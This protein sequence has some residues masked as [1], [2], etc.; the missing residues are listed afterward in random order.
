[1]VV[2]VGFFDGVHIG[3]RRVI[4]TLLDRG[5]DAVAVTFW[6]HPRVVLQQEAAGF[7]LLDTPQ[8]KLEKLNRAGITDVR[9]L[10]F[11]KAF[12]GKTAEQFIKE[13]LKDSL[14]CNCLVMGSDNSLG[15]DAVGPDKLAALCDRY[16]IETVVVPPCMVDG[17]KVSSSR[18]RECIGKGEIEEAN[19]MLG[20][21]YRI[22][23]VVVSGNR[24]GRTIGF[25]TINLQLSFPLKA[26]P[27]NGV[28]A[29]RTFIDGKQYQSMT[30][31]GVRPTVTAGMERVIETNIFDFNDDVY[32]Y[33]ASVEFISGI[34][35][36]MKF[37]SIEEL[38]KQLNIDRQQ[39]LGIK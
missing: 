26:I 30:N 32:G 36:E 1:M 5:E 14:D 12:A 7:Y 2:T 22:D 18:I 20:Q 8:Q 35:K 17:R 3:H 27:A 16:G 9:V 23:G 29:T 37:S 24:L 10:P 34:R 15:C 33:E 28:Y 11:D 38:S 25:P 21:P 19:A 4:Q 39:C 31:I 6:P 13:Y